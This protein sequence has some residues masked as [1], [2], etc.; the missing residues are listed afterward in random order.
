MGKI[1]LLVQKR[2]NRDSMNPKQP[3]K[4]K[5]EIEEQKI[6]GSHLQEILLHFYPKLALQ[7][8]NDRWGKNTADLKDQHEKQQ[9][10]NKTQKRRLDD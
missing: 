10:V 1:L 9:R 7:P 3:S 8:Q 5:T 6:A 4:N 2:G